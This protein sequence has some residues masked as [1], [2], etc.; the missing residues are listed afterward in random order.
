[1]NENEK[2]LNV[3]L[4]NARE[5]HEDEQI[6]IS[7]VGILRN[8]RRFFALWLAITIIASVLALVGTALVKRDSY[9]KTVSLVSFTFSG[10][11]NGLD[12]KGNTFDINT[13]KSPQI[14]ESALD[15]L[16]FPSDKL[17]D[18]RK[19]ISFEA[20]RPEEEVE[21]LTAYKNIFDAGTG[22]SMNAIGE[23]LKT[24]AYPSTYKVY[25]DY[26]PT[27]LTDTEAASVLNTMLE[28]YSEYFMEAYGYNKSLGSSLAALDYKDYDYAEA[29]DVFDDALNKI[30]SY[31]SQ[32]EKTEIQNGSST[33]SNRFRSS[34]TGYTFPDL[35]ETI[36][37]LRTID[38]ER[39]SSYVT[40]N[41]ITK[42]KDTL[43]TN[44]TYQVEL[45]ERQK[46]V[47][48]DSLAT[49]NAS[50]AGYQKNT[51][52]IYGSDSDE[53][54]NMTATQ[55]SEEYDNLFRK[56]EQI[57]SDLSE[58]IQ[59][60]NLYN[61]RIERLNSSTAVNSAAKKAKV[62]D[63][64]EK[65]DKQLKELIDLV[66]RTTDDFYRTVVFSK[67][68]NILVPANSSN[69]NSA[70]RA[71]TDAVMPIAIADAIIFV[72]YFA[73]AFVLSCIEEYAKEDH[74]KK[75]K[76]EKEPEAAAN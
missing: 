73:V 25:F 8:L 53:K 50:I 3:T 48:S 52:M 67:A 40:I 5:E 72:I 20:I 68:Y 30:S 26:A 51:V 61:K 14:I 56:K 31:V 71:L 28:C 75:N 4:T 33:N 37:T 59:K 66:N 60:I 6:S 64:L 54:R 74:E 29:I 21:R 46:A 17:E 12:P 58:T 39:I 2:Y 44:Y 63:D 19:N 18:I 45:L 16:G 32:V 70:T 9:K 76:K 57:Q 65:L 1:M 7:I 47:Y 49:I 34:D 11:E 41:T 10:I 55:A 36:S 22:N 27:G 13:L 42:D 35:S 38:L 23:L 62:E 69:S 24:N 43:L 15:E